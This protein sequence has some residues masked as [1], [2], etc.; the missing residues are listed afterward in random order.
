MGAATGCYAGET[1]QCPLA[2]HNILHVNYRNDAVAEHN[3]I[4]ECGYR[5]PNPQ[6]S[7]KYCY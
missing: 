5:M 2:I 4:V 1:D 6:M 3:Q 7:T